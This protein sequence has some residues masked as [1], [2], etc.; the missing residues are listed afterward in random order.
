MIKYDDGDMKAYTNAALQRRLKR[1]ARELG[2]HVEKVGWKV[3]ASDKA[4]AKKSATDD[5]AN[6]YLRDAQAENLRP[7]VPTVGATSPRSKLAG[8]LGASRTMNNVEAKMSTALFQKGQRVRVWWGKNKAS[9]MFYFL[10][11]KFTANMQSHIPT[12]NLMRSPRPH[13][14]TQE[15]SSIQTSRRKSW[16]CMMTVK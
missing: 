15:L 13:R 1:A 11:K 10:V 14:S 8:K 5:Q 3:K 12:K 9:C 6:G 7:P 2:I 4:S 16:S